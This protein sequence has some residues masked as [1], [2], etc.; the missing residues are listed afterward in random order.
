MPKRASCFT[1]HPLVTIPHS[2][3]TPLHVYGGNYRHPADDADILI[4]LESA[5]YRRDLYANFP[6]TKRDA[7]L[8]PIVNNGVPNISDLRNLLD[9]LEEELLKGRVAHIGC[10][11]GHGRTGL[12]LSALWNQCTGDANSTAILRETY[13]H[14]AVESAAQVDYLE[15]HFG[16][17]PVKPRYNAIDIGDWGLPTTTEIQ[18]RKRHRRGSVTRIKREDT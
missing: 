8:F 14:K 10:I 12:V 13:C 6:W 2:T 11:G 17:E 4:A 5:G 9:W 3:G 16:I 18:R 15:K 1:Q 7:F